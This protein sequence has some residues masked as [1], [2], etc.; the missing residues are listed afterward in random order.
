[1][2]ENQTGEILET[3]YNIVSPPLYEIMVVPSR[4]T[5][6]RGLD[7]GVN[8]FSFYISV[9]LVLVLILSSDMFGVYF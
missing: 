1:M 2:S 9:S 6:R 4:T 5:G 8:V 7:G 3:D